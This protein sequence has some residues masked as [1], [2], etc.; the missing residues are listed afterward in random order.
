MYINY[1]ELYHI[2]L[3]VI[4]YIL[5]YPFIGFK[6]KPSTFQNKQMFYIFSHNIFHKS[7]IKVVQLSLLVALMAARWTELEKLW[8]NN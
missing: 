1:Y 7:F 5:E 6:E 8:N 4:H 3:H 2:L